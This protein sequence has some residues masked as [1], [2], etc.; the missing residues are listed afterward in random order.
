[1][2]STKSCSIECNFL[3]SFTWKKSLSFSLCI[4]FIQNLFGYQ[5]V[6]FN[7]FILSNFIYYNFLYCDFAVYENEILDKGRI[8]NTIKISL[9][10]VKR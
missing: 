3:E 7:F 8:W 4:Y 2:I 10:K 1:M 9:I 6:D 5:L